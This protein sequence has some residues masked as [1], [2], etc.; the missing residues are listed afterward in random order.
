[1]TDT[2]TKTKYQGHVIDRL[3]TLD[4]RKTKLYDSYYEAH[5]AAE[6]LCERTMGER[7]EINVETR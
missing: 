7:G 6:K 4:A 3:G 5:K 2:V 1:M